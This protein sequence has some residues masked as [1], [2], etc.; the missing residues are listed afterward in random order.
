MNIVASYRAV[1]TANG[2]AL[3]LAEVSEFC[4]VRLGVKFGAGRS[5]HY[6]LVHSSFLVK[7][8]TILLGH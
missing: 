7:S 3:S 6:T 8:L 4:N 2:R 1:K 5:I